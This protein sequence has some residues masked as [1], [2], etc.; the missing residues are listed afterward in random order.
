MLISRT[1]EKQRIHFFQY[2]N[3]KIQN[4]YKF[5]LLQDEISIKAS[6][7]SAP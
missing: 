5:V 1:K 4:S 3:D 7:K 6:S 2:A